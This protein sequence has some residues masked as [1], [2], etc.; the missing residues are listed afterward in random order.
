MGACQTAR[1]EE[2]F[3]SGE[4]SFAQGGH[5]MFERE[6]KRGVKRAKMERRETKLPVAWKV[7]KEK[8]L[9]GR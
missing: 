4:M 5:E 3:M 1:E 6:S 8:D 7:D 9:S 2:A